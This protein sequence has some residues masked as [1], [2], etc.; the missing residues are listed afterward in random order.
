MRISKNNS[1]WLSM[2]FVAAIFLGDVWLVKITLPLSMLILPFI[3]FDRSQLGFKPFPTAA[4]PL[5]CFGAMMVLQCAVYR[6]NPAFRPRSDMAIWMPL[7]YAGTAIIALRNTKITETSLLRAM[8]SGGMITSIIMLGM[9]SFA[10]SNLFLVPG[11]NAAQVETSYAE[12]L[13]KSPSPQV[14]VQAQPPRAASKSESSQTAADSTALTSVSQDAAI[15][16]AEDDNLTSVIIEEKPVALAGREEFSSGAVDKA[17]YDIKNKSKNFLGQSNY[18]AV[19]LVFLFSVSLFSGSPFIA[20][21][22]AIL[23]II[24]LSRFGMVF[25]LTV[26]AVYF[27]RAGV[28]PVIGIATAGA[29]ICIGIIALFVWGDLLPPIPGTASMASRIQYWQSGVDALGLHTIIGAPRSVSLVAL[30]HNITW[31]PHNSVLWIAVNFGIIGIAAYVVYIWIIMRE[32]GS[33]ARHSEIWM[34]ILIGVATILIW[35]LLE[36]IILTPAFEILLATLYVLA[37]SSRTLVE[38][39]SDAIAAQ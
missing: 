23:T 39:R 16:T 4:I 38:H 8:Y 32:L 5:L 18:I 36:A 10:P 22:F 31:N 6:N 24:T 9:I 33:R 27:L 1:P 3:L 28:N 11:Q 17:F 34:G 12:S 13:K 21:F 25:L 14:V 7:V 30:D 20:G 2:F 35:S 26:T 15:G 29:A 19:F 37:H